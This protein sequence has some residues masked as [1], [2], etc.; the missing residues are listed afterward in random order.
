[1]ELAM[2]EKSKQI[3]A[4]ALAPSLEEFKWRSENIKTQ[5]PSMKAT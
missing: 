5:L 4:L 1:M 3:A 2:K